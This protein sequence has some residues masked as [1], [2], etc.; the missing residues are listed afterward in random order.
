MFLKSGARVA[1]HQ[2]PIRVHDV[3]NVHGAL[4]IVQDC[5][6]MRALHTYAEVIFQV[7][8]TKRFILTNRAVFHA[9]TARSLSSGLQDLPARNPGMRRKY[10]LPR[11]ICPTIHNRERP[12]SGCF[13]SSNSSICVF[14]HKPPAASTCR[15]LWV[16]INLSYVW[17]CNCGE[18]AVYQSRQHLP[19]GD[20]PPYLVSFWPASAYSPP[21]LG[22]N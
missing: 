9:T 7:L 15:L 17:T 11:A 20:V 14:Y 22:Q 8:L 3:R 12:L 13:C 19:L 5:P 2:P 4:M 16:R 6:S 1:I 18:T 21:K 10:T